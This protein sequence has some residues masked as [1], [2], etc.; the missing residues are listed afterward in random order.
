M[1]AVMRRGGMGTAGLGENESFSVSAA[2]M[3]KL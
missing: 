1:T 2:D 3:V